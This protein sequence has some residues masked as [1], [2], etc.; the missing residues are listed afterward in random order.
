M[1]H[2]EYERQLLESLNLK[3][4]NQDQFPPTDWTPPP[5]WELQG[6]ARERLPS[7][8]DPLYFKDGKYK[9]NTHG[10]KDTGEQP[11]VEDLA[12]DELRSEWKN[13]RVFP[14]G[15]EGPVIRN[16][17]EMREAMK[18]SGQRFRERGEKYD[19]PLEKAHKRLER[20]ARDLGL[21]PKRE[22]EMVR[23]QS[24]EVDQKR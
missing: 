15:R 24:Y 23:A 1:K 8:V 9:F 12:C 18:L 14:D 13:Y 7:G 10:H 21:D 19:N 3:N 2:R 11:F 16:S 5:G 4:P 20:R 6:A 17:D 22:K